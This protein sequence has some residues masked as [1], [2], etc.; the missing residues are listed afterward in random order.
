MMVAFRGRVM[1]ESDFEVIRFFE[2]RQTSNKGDFLFGAKHPGIR[3][4]VP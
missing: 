1:F 3:G 4:S 2:T